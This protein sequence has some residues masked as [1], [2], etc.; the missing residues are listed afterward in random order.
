MNPMGALSH[1][2]ESEQSNAPAKGKGKG[3]SSP[4]PE[5]SL[6]RGVAV[7]R[8]S[9]AALLTRSES[10]KPVNRSSP[11]QPLVRR[12]E[13]LIWVPHHPDDAAGVALRQARPVVPAGRG[14]LKSPFLAPPEAPSLATE[15]DPFRSRFG[16]QDS[17]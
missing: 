11:R 12:A 15:I 13:V 17:P 5:V 10:R 4:R 14:G 2:P 8:Q 3:N 7:N 9:P 16:G 1:R 6:A